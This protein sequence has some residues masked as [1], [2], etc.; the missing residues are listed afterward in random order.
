MKLR[1]HKKLCDYRLII[2]D[3]D[4]TLYYQAPLRFCMCIELMLYYAVHLCRISEL[5]M[6]YKFRKSYESGVLEQGNHIIEYW[7]QEKPL[8]YI[9]MFR[10]KKLLSLIRQL[11]EKGGKVAIYS[12]FPVMQKIKILRDLTIDYA[13]CAADPV[14]QCVKPDPAGLKNIL[15]IA[16]EIAENSLFIGDRYEKDGKCAENAGVDYIILD[17]NSLLRNINLYKKELLYVGTGKEE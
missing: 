4:G 2:L 10:D 15:R 3:M 12:D 5:V 7:M 6:L 14:V 17:N 8:R 1:L 16:G 11:R 9:R 13:F